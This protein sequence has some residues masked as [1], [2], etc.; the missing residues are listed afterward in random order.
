MQRAMPRFNVG[1]RVLIVRK[2]SQSY[3][4]NAGVVVG[5]RQDAIRSILDEYTIEFSDGTKDDF[6]AFQ[7]LEDGSGYPTI[8]AA[9]ALD[10]P[11]GIA[12]KHRQVA[13]R[14]VIL[15]TQHIDIDLR[16]RDYM[17]NVYIVGQILERGTDRFLSGVQVSLIRDGAPIDSTTTTGFGEFRF[18]KVPKGSLNIEVLLREASSRILGDF[19]I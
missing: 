5:I 7:L 10:T 11:G 2:F 13:T 1:D 9:L 19:S 4:G 8:A 6:F 18:N 17:T 15:R 14:Q 12:S 3:P 16:L